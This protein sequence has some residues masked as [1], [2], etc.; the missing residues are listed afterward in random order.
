MGLNIKSATEILK[1]AITFVTHTTNK[2]TD[3]SVGSVTRTIL[4]SVSLQLEEFYFKIYDGL[5]YAIENSVLNAFGFEIISAEYA[6]GELTVEFRN[7]LTSEFKFT[8]GLT[9]CTRSTLSTIKY[10]TLVSDTIAP[11]GST[12]ITL[13]VRCTTSGVIGNTVAN[14]ITIMVTANSLVSKIYNATAFTNGR[15]AETKAERKVRFKKYLAS[16][17]RGTAASIEYA[18]ST[19]EGISGVYVDDKI[20]VVNVYCHD[21]NG[22]LS[23]ALK[24]N[25]EAVTDLYRSAGV[26]VVVYSVTKTLVDITATV[27][28]N[29]GYSTS[30]YK[31]IVEE[32]ISNYMYSIKVD[33]PLYLTNLIKYIANL[34]SD[35]IVDVELSVPTSNIPASSRVLLRPGNI[36]VSTQIVG[37]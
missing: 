13:N 26:E 18:A 4:E 15:A 20:G 6:S 22:D 1:S 23:D 12:S 16:L 33:K 2:I 28:L 32:G 25:V 21:A 31:T 19:V 37:S 14:S 10:Y 27:I 35:A 30:S 11:S 36:N 7:A 29:E 8:A 9:F 17:V 24:A 5:L 34:D 3:F